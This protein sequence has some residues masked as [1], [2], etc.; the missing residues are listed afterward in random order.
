M[1]GLTVP[2]S[3]TGVFAPLATLGLLGY[4]PALAAPPLQAAL[5]GFSAGQALQGAI[6]SDFPDGLWDP[7]GD[8][9]GQPPHR[10]GKDV[11]VQPEGATGV[12]NVSIGPLSVGGPGTSCSPA[13]LATASP[14]EA[15]RLLSI[16]LPLQI[17]F[18]WAWWAARRRG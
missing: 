18:A 8:R 7:F 4:A 10:Q 6:V 16:L 12:L 3:Q 1:I 5:A 14:P 15:R 17:L 9:S 2:P 11:Q 13:A